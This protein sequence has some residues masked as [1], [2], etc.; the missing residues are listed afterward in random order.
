VRGSRKLE[1][2][3]FWFPFPVPAK[4]NLSRRSVF[5]ELKGTGEG[6]RKRGMSSVGR[7]WQEQGGYGLDLV[8]LCRTV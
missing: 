7:V 4:R 5:F 6:G 2:F 8:P 3:S 1:R